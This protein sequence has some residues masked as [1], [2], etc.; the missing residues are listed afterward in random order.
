MK[1]LL[2]THLL[3]WALVTPER[4]PS[5]VVAKLE[6]ND[7]VPHFS[8][9]SI[10]ETAIKQTLQRPDFQVDVR[11]FL[12]HLLDSGFVEMPIKAE[13]A[14]F[15][16]NLPMIH[17]DPFDRLLVAQANVEGVLLLTS[18]RLVAAYPGPIRLV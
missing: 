1:L 18:D 11:L 4:L 13:H 5:D 2:D 3:L 16:G 12:S 9:A 17:K 7:N 6:D 8:A 14:A 15:L 10:A